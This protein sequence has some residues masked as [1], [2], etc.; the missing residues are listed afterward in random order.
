MIVCEFFEK[1]AVKLEMSIA[2]FYQ[3]NKGLDVE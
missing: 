3:L 1:Y 2:G